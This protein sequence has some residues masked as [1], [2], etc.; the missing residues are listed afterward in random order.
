V[1][2]AAKNPANLSQFSDEATDFHS[3]PAWQQVSTTR[4]MQTQGGKLSE[5]SSKHQYKTKLSSMDIKLHFRY[6]P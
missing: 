3:V 4:A 2:L 1:A 5:I 6:M